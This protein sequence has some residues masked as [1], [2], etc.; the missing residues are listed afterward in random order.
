M[1]EC[2]KYHARIT[3]YGI[4]EASTGTQQVF[5]A[6]DL[7]GRFDPASGQLVGC[8]PAERTYY[9]AITPKTIDWVLSD[10]KTVGF[11]KDSLKYLDP[12]VPGA[13]NLFGKEIDVV[14]DHETYNGSLRE[15]WSIQRER[16]RKKVGHHELSQLDVQFSDQLKKAFGDGK[17]SVAPP[18]AANTSNESF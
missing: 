18:V 6:F 15:R 1:Y 16:N 7:I 12:E 5:I 8:Q 11:D 17:P 4:T 9:K 14:C 2:G 3:D 13:V 10:L